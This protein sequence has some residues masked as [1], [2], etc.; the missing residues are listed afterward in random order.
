MLN[1]NKCQLLQVVLN[2]L[3]HLSEILIHSSTFLSENNIFTL[4]MQLL[5]YFNS[6]ILVQSQNYFLAAIHLSLKKC[7]SHFLLTNYEH[8]EC[9]EYVNLSQ[10]FFFYNQIF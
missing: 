3:I 9:L 8:F 1:Y 2:D 6:S 5:K 7:K 10:F 4:G